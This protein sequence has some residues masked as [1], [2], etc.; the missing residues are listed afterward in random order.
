MADVKVKTVDGETLDM[1]VSDD[2][3]RELVDWFDDAS[4]DPVV[5]LTDPTLGNIYLR[6]DHVIWLS[7][8]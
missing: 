1:E 4:K 5:N 7:V 6:R 3:A 2:Q 8:R